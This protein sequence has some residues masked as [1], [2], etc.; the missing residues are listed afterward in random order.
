MTMTTLALRL[1]VPLGLL[2]ACAC[3]SPTVRSATLAS[4]A[5]GPTPLASSPAPAGGAKIGPLLARGFP[6]GATTATIDHWSAG[7]LPKVLLLQ[8]ESAPALTLRGFS[9]SDGRPLRFWYRDGSPSVVGPAS[10][11]IPNGVLE[12]IGDETVVFEAFTLRSPENPLGHPGYMLF[13]SA[14]DWRLEVRGG[15]TLLGSVVIRV[16]QRS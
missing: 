2:V 11:P 13:T 10:T 12:M 4:C 5:D 1:L 16:I 3:I 8:V 14:G 6:E 9:C 15:D 7:S